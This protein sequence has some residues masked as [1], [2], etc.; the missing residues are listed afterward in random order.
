MKA[1]LR[2]HF[3]MKRNWVS[4]LLCFVSFCATAQLCTG[5]LGEPIVNITFGNGSPVGPPLDATVTSYTYVT[6]DCPLDGAYSVRSSSANCFGTWHA[7]NT[8]HTGDPQ[9][10]FMLV[11][12]SVDPGDFYVET[13]KGLCSNTTYE[14]AA[15]LMNVVRVPNQIQPNITFSIEKKDGTVLG[16]FQSGNIDNSGTPQWK[17]Y[18]FNFKT[19]PGVFEVVLRIRNIAPGGIGND[20]ALDDITFRACGPA[21]RIA[22][23]GRTDTVQLCEGDLKSFELNA[24]VPAF[25]SNP[26]LQWQIS[27]DRGATWHDLAGANALQL[28]VSTSDVGQY[29]YRLSAAEAENIT[30]LTCRVVSN[31]IAIHINANPKVSAG[32]DKVIIKGESGVLEGSLQGEKMTFAWTPP[33]FIDNVSSLMPAVTP[34]KTI[35]YRLSAKSSYGCTSSDDVLV[36]VV[37]GI[38]IPNS[39]TPNGDG[40]ND[41]WQIPNIEFATE[42]SVTIFNRYGN[43]IYQKRGGMVEWDGTFKGKPQPS[44]VYIYLVT[45]KASSSPTRGFLTLIR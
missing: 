30:S 40:R 41:R 9:G 36:K 6:S 38:Y 12:A 39:F 26:L 20:L 13:V 7:I 4:F 35:T 8:D 45:F 16:I 34:Q 24:V 18:G 31:I 1:C 25:Y 33:D 22:I 28:T 23:D 3:F 2:D 11:N 32:P 42:A 5:S 17:K 37:E 10:C 29:W 21:L 15:W 43:L 27:K 19:P 14:F 44:G